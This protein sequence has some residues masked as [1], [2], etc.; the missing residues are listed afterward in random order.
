MICAKGPIRIEDAGTVEHLIK[1]A[2]GLKRQTG[3]PWQ[4]ESQD[5]S[6]LTR[7]QNNHIELSD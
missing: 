6:W 1:R 3:S 4:V 2:H 5:C 7:V